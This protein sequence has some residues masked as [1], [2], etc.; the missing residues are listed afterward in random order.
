MLAR[1][2]GKCPAHPAGGGR[3]PQ[4]DDV[5][6]TDLDQAGAG[7]DFQA[8]GRVDAGRHAGQVLAAGQHHRHRRAHRAAA[9]QVFPAQPAAVGVT[10]PGLVQPGAVPAGKLVQHGRQQPFPHIHPVRSPLRGSRSPHVRRPRCP[11]RGRSR[12]R[13][14]RRGHPRPLRRGRARPLRHEQRGRGGHG[15]LA[16]LLEDVDPGPDHDRVTPALGQDPGHLGAIDQ[17]IVR[18]FQPGVHPGR[19]LQGR[20]DRHSGQQRHPAQQAGRHGGAQEHREGEGAARRADPPPPHPA[21]ARGLC[22]GHQHQALG[23]AG[24]RLGQQ[25]GVGGSGFLHHLDLAP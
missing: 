6:R 14:L 8:A 2:A 11:R 19:P 16:A 7:A 4:V 15:Q 25:V 13:R 12:A 20:R 24:T 21:T 9:P 18:P 5:P 17:H 22:L 23:G 3:P 1:S 10:G